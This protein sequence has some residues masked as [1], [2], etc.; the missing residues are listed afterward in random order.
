VAGL[1]T[2][3]L[4]CMAGG[5]MCRPTPLRLYFLQENLG[6]T[7]EY[8]GSVLSNLTMFAFA[9]VIIVCQLVIEIKR[10]VIIRKEKRADELAAAAVRQ[11][12]NATLRLDN[13]GF[14]QLGVQFLPR[15][16]WQDIAEDQIPTGITNLESPNSQN[17]SKAVALKISRYVS[18]FG[19]FPTILS[20]IALSLDNI[21][22]LRPHGAIAFMM[23][24]YGIVIPLTLILGNKKLRK[25]ARNP[26]IKVWFN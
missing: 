8:Y 24:I 26:K 15:L 18:I 22:S 19:I 21:D 2:G 13:T 1:G 11:I 16:A 5:Y 25:F 10:Y 20:I 3:G 14:H 17:T 7:T 9:S 4:M 23:S 12:Q 6:A